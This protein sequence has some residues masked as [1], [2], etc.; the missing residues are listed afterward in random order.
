[1]RQQWF[2]DARFGMFVHF[3]AYSVAAR[4]EWVQNYERLTDD[5][6]RPYI[7][8]FDPD[9]FDALAIARRA[10][11]TGMGYV[12]LT[13]KHH[14]GFCLFDSALTDFTSQM[15]CGRD[16]VR[17]HVEAA[18][19]EGL[20][21][22]IY[23]SVIDWHHPDFTVDWNHP[24]RDDE[25]ASDLN[26]GRDMARYRDYLHGQ[27]RE[28][29]TRYG[30]I[31]YLFFDWT[32]P[33]ARDG[34]QGKGPQDWD[35]EALLALCREL[36]PEM[37][38]NDRLGIPADFVT[39]EQY[40]PTSPLVDETGERQIWEACQTLNGSWGYHR[41]NTDQ[42]SAT[43]LVQMLADSVSMDGNMLLNIGPDG[44][45]AIAPRDG[46]TLDEIGDWMLLHRDAI[47]G[48]GHADLRPP[49]EGVYTRRGDRLYLH[50]FSWPLGFVHLPDLAGR[51][52]FARLLNDGSW[53]KTSTSDPD[54][55]AENITPAG[56]AEGT[57]TVHLPVRRPDVLVPVIE[58]TLRE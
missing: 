49:R 41:D 30:R 54:Q 25:N 16:L 28:L 45:G 3:G 38:V 29:L 56:E 18:R 47:I 26:R 40:Q 36:Q 5:E 46:R 1:M 48:A 10:K 32:Y 12:V 50:L 4:H 31:D 11:A 14:D 35:A 43:L 2:D 17:E 22:G 15:V 6:Y 8:H 57:L 27:V 39:P 19:A 44:R 9:R 58:L 55:R 52:S 53:L 37:L 21:V 7:D 34:W 23:Y 20:R 13:A 51:V 24:R 33:E 42:K